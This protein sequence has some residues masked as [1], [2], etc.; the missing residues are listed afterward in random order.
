MNNYLIFLSFIS[1]YI[2]AYTFLSKGEWVVGVYR[3]VPADVDG[4]TCRASF[5]GWVV[6]SNRAGFEV[7]SA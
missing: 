1:L 3:Q 7:G 6:C 4:W 5:P 2:C